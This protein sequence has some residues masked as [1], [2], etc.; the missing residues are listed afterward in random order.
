M[1]EIKSFLI[2]KLFKQDGQDK[3]DFITL[4]FKD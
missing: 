3:Q 2:F 4:I 1:K